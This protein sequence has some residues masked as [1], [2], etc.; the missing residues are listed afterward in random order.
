MA[1]R[2][3]D[4]DATNDA[5]TEVRLFL[6]AQQNHFPVLDERA[7]RLAQRIEEAGGAERYLSNRHGV[8][9]RRLPSDVM[10]GSLRRLDYHRKE[11]VLDQTLDGA[12]RAFQLSL[13]T[14]YIELSGELNGAVSDGGFSTENGRI[15]ARRAVA[16]YGAGALMMPYRQFLKAAEAHRYDIE[17]LA[18]QFGA[19]FEQAAHRLTTLHRHGAKGVPFFSSV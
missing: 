5:L 12:S 6:T 10:A 1:D 2:A 17:V 16:N 15:L 3:L 14:V 19:S 8:T 9:V 4:I 11:L 18:R 13:Q 7:E